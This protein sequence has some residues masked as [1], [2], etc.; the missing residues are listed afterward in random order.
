VPARRT[1]T[2]ARG[3][4]P[5]G[6]QDIDLIMDVERRAFE[7]AMQADEHTVL[8][9]LAL[10]HSVLGIRGPDGHLLG[11]IGYSSLHLGDTCDGLPPRFKEY[12]LQV[13]PPDPDTYCIYSLGVAPEARNLAC[14][15]LLLG[16][17]FADGRRRGFRRVIGDGSIPSLRGND[18]VAPR[19][20]IREMIDRY[21]RT[22]RF[23]EQHEFLRDPLLAFYQRIVHCR[24]VK[25]MPDFLPEDA[26][27]EG[28]RVLLE[29]TL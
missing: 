27:S 21:Q 4:V 28:W 17:V 1:V 3:L 15:R 20:E 10:G 9:R 2:S 14:S 18:Q 19:P 8:R 29:S 22:G 23:P 26:A 7:S 6:T 24:F 25:L 16:T 13:V 12:S 11:T 5:L